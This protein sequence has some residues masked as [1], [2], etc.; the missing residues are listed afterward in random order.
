[1]DGTWGHYAKQNK[2]DKDIQILNDLNYMCNLKT[3]QNTKLQK[4]GD[5]WLSEVVGGGRRE[6]LK[7]VKKYELSVIT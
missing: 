2:L 4:K 3:K 6:W 5:L 1:M 7:L